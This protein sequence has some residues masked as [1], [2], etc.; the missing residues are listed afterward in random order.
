M[1]G[2]DQFVS[3]KV[4]RRLA[5]CSIYGSCS[6]K[7]RDHNTSVDHQHA[8]FHG[9]MSYAVYR[10]LLCHNTTVHHQLAAL[11]GNMCNVSNRTFRPRSLE[12]SDSDTTDQDHGIL[13]V[14]H[15]RIQTPRTSFMKNLEGFA[16]ISSEGHVFINI[17]NQGIHVNIK[18]LLSHFAKQALVI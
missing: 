14:F 1:M 12:H 9:N 5:R 11:H 10:M 4:R 18:N 13:H 16:Y 8:A 2:V 6:Y 7:L 3:K 15:T 17:I